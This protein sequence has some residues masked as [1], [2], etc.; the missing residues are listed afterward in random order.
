METT[1]TAK[2]AI[3]SKAMFDIPL[4]EISPSESVRDKIKITKLDP[5][6]KAD[7]EDIKFLYSVKKLGI[8]QPIT[9]RRN[10]NGDLEIVSGDRRY[11]AAKRAGHKTIPAYEID[12]DSESDFLKKA[13]HLNYSKPNKGSALAIILNS[14]GTESGNAKELSAEYGVSEK[15]VYDALYLSTKEELCALSRSNF[16]NAVYLKGYAIIYKAPGIAS[17][18]QKS[19][20]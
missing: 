4:N 13:Y 9:V 15:V 10:G 8:L 5:T 16:K 11:I 20:Y 2:S 1:K 7:N 18:C 14:T 3:T 19:H 6:N 12:V 17:I